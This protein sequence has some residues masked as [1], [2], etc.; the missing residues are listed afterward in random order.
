MPEKE[1]A[2]MLAAK[3]CEAC[4]PG[5]PAVDDVRGGVS[6]SP[7][8]LGAAA[9]RDRQAVQLQELLRDDG[10]RERRGVVSPTAG[11]SPGPGGGVQQVPGALQHARGRR[12]VENDFICAAKIEQ[13][14]A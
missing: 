2:S 14:F 12:A 13:L 10:V 11:P 4:Q 9:G 1:T 7:A 5:M 3:K 6:Q 8:R